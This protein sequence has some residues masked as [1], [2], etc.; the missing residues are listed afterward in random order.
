MAVPCHHA[1][2]PEARPRRLRS[3][4][5]SRTLS[6]SPP[7]RRTRSRPCTGR[8]ISAACCG[9]AGST[10]AR[11]PRGIPLRA[12]W[13][14]WHRMHNLSGGGSPLGLPPPGMDSLRR[15][16]GE[17]QGRGG[18][19][20]GGGAGPGAGPGKAVLMTTRTSSFTR[21]P[22]PHSSSAHPTLP[23]THPPVI[24]PHP[25]SHPLTHPATHPIPSFPPST[26]PPTRLGHFL[27]G[28]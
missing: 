26:Y 7:P 18:S 8:R 9:W 5:G 22:S 14:L 11:S 6:V 15:A 3:M 25:S 23:R 4:R 21:H 10:G 28:T 1:G 12:L 27:Q 24:L 16:A 20:G 17:S 2:V 13:R 19:G